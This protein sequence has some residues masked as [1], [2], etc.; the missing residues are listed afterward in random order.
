MGCLME[1]DQCLVMGKLKKNKISNLKSLIIISLP[2][3]DKEVL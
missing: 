2:L 3:E 1:R